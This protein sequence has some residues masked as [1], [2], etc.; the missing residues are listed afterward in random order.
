MTE[1]R[2][3]ASAGWHAPLNRP[4]HTRDGQT[5]TT[6]AEARDFALNL[7]ANY[8]QRNHWQHAARIML[9]VAEGGSISAASE[10]IERALFLDKRLD[11]M[12]TPA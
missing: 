6:L 3:R 8:S 9:E 7:P 1:K 4:L 11:V 5:I 12:K 10:Q 2:K